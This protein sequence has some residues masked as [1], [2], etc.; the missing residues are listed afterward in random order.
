MFS[1]DVAVAVMTF[2]NE[3][4]VKR[5]RPFLGFS[6]LWEH[7]KFFFKFVHF[8]VL[9]VGVA[10]TWVTRAQICF[11]FCMNR[12]TFIKC[13]QRKEFGTLQASQGIKTCKQL[14]IHVTL[15]TVV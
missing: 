3:T 8:R 7:A 10:E 4:S 15:T 14:R 2:V 9:F 12:Y 1:G 11:E 13:S 5:M 6:H